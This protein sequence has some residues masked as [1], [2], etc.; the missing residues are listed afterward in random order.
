MHGILTSG[1]RR[2][3]TPRQ[4][5]RRRYS[6]HAGALLTFFGEH[7][8]ALANQVQRYFPEQLPLDRTTRLHLQSLVANGDLAITR[9]RELGQPNVYRITAVGLSAAAVDSRC[10]TERRLRRPAGSHLLHELLITEVAVMLREAE[11]KRSDLAI[12]WRQR[13]DLRAE[14]AF[15]SIVPDYAFLFRSG[16]GQLAA[17]TEVSCGEESTTRLAQKLLNYAEWASSS[18]SQEFLLNLYR[19]HG[20]QRPRP[21]FRLVFVVQNRR[22]GRDEIRLRQVLKASSAIPAL[23][24][25]RL[26]ITTVDRLSRSGS[27]DAQ[28]WNRGD[29]LLKSVGTGTAWKL[30]NENRRLLALCRDY[31]RITSF[32]VVRTSPCHC[33]RPSIERRGRYGLGDLPAWCG[34][35]DCLMLS[36]SVLSLAPCGCW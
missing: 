28:I 22:S 24:V 11:A 6:R 18:A 1:N 33:G 23:A 13:F 27:F 21:R 25:S 9:A 15:T 4:G 2:C 12:V 20:A 5:C 32:L 19:D 31:R 7:R 34:A 14:P 10:T 3:R 8:T 26:W 16:S 29:D 36:D 35:G 30:K 17:L